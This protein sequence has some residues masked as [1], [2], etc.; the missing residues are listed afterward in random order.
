P[1][2]FLSLLLMRRHG[3]QLRVLLLA[4]LLL[5]TGTGGTFYNPFW[6]WSQSWF[7][8]ENQVPLLIFL[9]RLL[10]LLLSAGLVL[11]AFLFPGGRFVPRWAPWAVGVW[12]YLR[13][14]AEFFPD[15]PISV[16]TWPL[17]R[18]LILNTAIILIAA[19]A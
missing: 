12:V 9:S 16:Y 14:G 10:N 1:Y 2:L 17:N 13:F 5:L 19:V 7:T 3:E 18:G 6:G 15:T 11:F 8:V 4:S